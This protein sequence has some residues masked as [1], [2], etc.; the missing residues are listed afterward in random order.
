MSV[1]SQFPHQRPYVG[2]DEQSELIDQISER[3]G[4]SKAQVTRF[5][6]N[7]TYGFTETGRLLPGDTVDE[8]VVAAMAR[9]DQVHE[10]E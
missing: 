9:L 4:I 2:T 7:E 6:L 1:K 8:L 10:K 3:L 5:A